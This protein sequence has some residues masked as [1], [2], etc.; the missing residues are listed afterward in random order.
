MSG[1]HTVRR[2]WTGR[3]PLLAYLRDVHDPPA[4]AFGRVPV[5][6]T[7]RVLDDQRESLVALCQE[8][9][10]MAAGRNITS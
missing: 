10:I 2:L 1:Q 8:Y 6:W 5:T 9:P 3:A 4:S 7:G